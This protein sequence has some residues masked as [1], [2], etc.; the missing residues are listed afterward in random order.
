MHDRVQALR[1][2][3]SQDQFGGAQVGPQ[4]FRGAARVK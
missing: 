2:G 1:D 4:H 3:L